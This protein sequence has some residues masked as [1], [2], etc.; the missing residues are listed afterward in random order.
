MQIPCRQ[1][2]EPTPDP[3]THD[4]RPDRAAHDEANPGWLACVVSDQQVTDQE[5]PAGPAACANHRGEFLA[6]AHP[7]RRGKHGSAP[8]LGRRRR[9]DADSGT[10]LAPPGRQDCAPGA[11]AHAQPEPVRLR[12]TAIVRL[13]R[14][15]AH[16]NSRYGL[17]RSSDGGHGGQ[18]CDTRVACGA[19]CRRRAGDLGETQ[20]NQRYVSCPG[21]S[22]T[23][24]RVAPTLGVCRTYSP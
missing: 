23:E 11:G 9:S 22:S 13:K 10:A 5:R 6:N 8:P 14:A 20:A 16:G 15:L 21:R 19:R 24:Y 12:A 7:A 2:P 3:V 17:F 18:H 4:R 1:V